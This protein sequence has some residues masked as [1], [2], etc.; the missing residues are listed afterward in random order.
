ME[1][2]KL[3]RYGRKELVG[4]IVGPLFIVA[5]FFL[6]AG[7]PDLYRGWIWAGIT[8]LFY[9]V[10]MTVILRVNPV[11]LNERGGW[12]RR[13]DSKSWDRIL[14]LVYA[15]TG[16]YGHIILMAFDAGRYGWSGM[17][18]WFMLPGILLYTCSFTLVYWSMAV[19]KH[20]ETTVRVQ[21][22]RDHEVVTRGPYGIVRHPGYS[23]LALANFATAMII[24]SW[25]GFITA[26]A[27]LVIL[28]IR[29]WLEDRIL[30]NELEGYREYAEKTRYRL[31]PLIW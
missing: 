28:G 11:L 19:N 20:F 18:P 2:V 5:L 12:N 9:I 1:K 4:H 29:T 23:G 21:H 17:H 22:E 13:K 7:R 14:L 3:N 15:G 8:F 31:F 6:V 27:T 26:G 16:L 30:I 25:F 24:G 10:G